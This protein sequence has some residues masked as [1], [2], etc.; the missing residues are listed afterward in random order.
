M[1]IKPGVDHTKYKKVMVDYVI[2]AFAHDSEYKGIDANEMKKLAD[3]AS[4]ALVNALKGRM[5]IVSEPGPYA[6]SIEA[7]FSSC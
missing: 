5:P 4:L 7:K 6:G 1:W 2:F 3:T